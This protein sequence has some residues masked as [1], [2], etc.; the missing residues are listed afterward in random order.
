[1]ILDLCKKKKKK[2][3][4]ILFKSPDLGDFCYRYLNV[5]PVECFCFSLIFRNPLYNLGT[6]QCGFYLREMPFPGLW[7]VFSFSFD[8]LM[9]T[10]N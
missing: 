10:K 2:K 7:L 9:Y 8:V 5:S 3:T 4:F 6:S 1:M